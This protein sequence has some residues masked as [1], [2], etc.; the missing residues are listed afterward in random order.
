[1]GDHTSTDGPPG[2]AKDD[3]VFDKSNPNIAHAVPVG[4]GL[5]MSE[6]GDAVQRRSTNTY[7]DIVEGSDSERTGTSWGVLGV[8]D[9]ERVE[10][11]AGLQAEGD[12]QGEAAPNRNTGN[13]LTKDDL[14]DVGSWSTIDTED[15]AGS[16]SGNS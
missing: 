15:S 13:R 5:I 6:R 1:M 2:I 12:Q 14:Q 11:P 4:E 10:T 9:A 16:P 7:P 8:D 3:I